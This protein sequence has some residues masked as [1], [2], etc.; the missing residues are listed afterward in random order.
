MQLLLRKMVPDASGL[1]EYSD[2]ELDADAILIGS[3]PQCDIQI[4]GEGIAPRH[5]RLHRVAKHNVL[6]AEAGQRFILNGKPAKKATLQTGDQ[7]AIGIQ[8]FACTE[9]P[10]GFDLALEWQAE[11]VEGHWL[12]GAYRTSLDDL[13]FSP[14]RM[15]WLLAV[16]ILVCAGLAP[17]LHYFW[18]SPELTAQSV[19]QD[20][21]PQNFWRSGPL[22]SA[23]Q[24]AIGNNC[25]A[26]HQ[27][28]FVQVQDKACES[29]HT[30]MADHV[31]ASHPQVAGFDGFACQNCHKEHNEPQS[32]VPGSDA[33]CTDC[34]QKEDPAVSGFSQEQHPEFALS[35][36][37]PSVAFS[38]GSFDVSWKQEKKSR[39]ETLQETNHLK[40]PHDV[41]LDAEKVSHDQRDGPMVC[42]DCHQLSSDREHFEPITM[43]EHCSSCHELSFDRNNPQKQLPHG[44]ASEVYQALEAH[45]VGVAFGTIKTDQFERRRLPAREWQEDKCD[46][47]FAC[48]QRQALREAEQQF[49]K[50]GC[51]TCHEVKEVAKAERAE[52]WQVLPVKLNQNWFAGSR[53]DHQSHLTQADSSGDAVCLSCHAAD[54]SKASTDILMPELQQC[55]TCHGDTSV[56][57]RVPLN[58]I[59]CHGYHLEDKNLSKGAAHGAP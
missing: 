30:D 11:E 59:A 36:L 41:H 8:L 25:S 15:S 10:S 20:V 22:L 26:C 47:D 32:I 33:V 18:M 40:F 49:M 4:L 2:R 56:S 57:D 12:A 6:R 28:A 21:T 38:N 51:I 45:F 43:Q 13:Q 46:K 53:F 42:A 31:E 19:N 34:H 55:T 3:S 54:R 37:Q 1:I 27:A 35:L 16:L 52:R 39:A 7:V 29:C 9:P 48:A 14:R 17:V 58:C 5:A 23:H 50:S 24:I 44:T